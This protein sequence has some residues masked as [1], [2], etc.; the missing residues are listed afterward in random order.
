MTGAG[1][2]FGAAT[3]VGGAVAAWGAATGGGPA[4][5]GASTTC[6]QCGHRTCLPSNSAGT[7]M[8][9]PQNGQGNVTVGEAMCA[10]VKDGSPPGEARG[11][12]RMLHSNQPAIK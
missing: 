9:R 3:G 11:L 8:R 6:L 7:P 4:V 10:F 2:G 12:L 5:A 1:V